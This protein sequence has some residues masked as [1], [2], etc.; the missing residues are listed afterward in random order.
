MKYGLITTT[1]S[2]LALALTASLATAADAPVKAKQAPASAPAKAAAKK[3]KPPAPKVELVDINSA[4]KDELK[5]LPGIGD[6]EADKIVA[7]RPYLSKAH[8]QTRNII[9]AGTYLGL[10][11][12]VIAKQKDAKFLE[13]KK[14]AKPAKGAK[15]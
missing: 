14:D 5:K 11:D 1:L 8:L 4:S 10:K 7:G 2:A 6:K 13:E 3:D 12:L 15:K 9:P